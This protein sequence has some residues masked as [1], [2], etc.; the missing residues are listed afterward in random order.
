MSQGAT[1]QAANTEEISSS[2]E[3]IAV[4]TSKDAED[5]KKTLTVGSSVAMAV[6]MRGAW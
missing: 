5:G 1:E 3:G 6:A 4:K 2:V